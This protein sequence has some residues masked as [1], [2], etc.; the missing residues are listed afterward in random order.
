M[1]KRSARSDVQWYLPG[2]KRPFAHSTTGTSH[3]IVILGGMGLTVA[4]AIGN[5]G[6][7]WDYDDEALAIIQ[8]FADAGLGEILL[9]DLVG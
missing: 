3:L 8:K 9:S 2:S 7:T 6:L 1:A 4:D 5:Y